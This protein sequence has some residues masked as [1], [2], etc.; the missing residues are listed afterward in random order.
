MIATQIAAGGERR[1][2]EHSERTG[3][4]QRG[5]VQQEAGG[6]GIFDDSVDVREPARTHAS[7]QEHAGRSLERAVPALTVDASWRST[8]AASKKP[9]AFTIWTP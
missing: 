1:H 9:V 5:D 8:A 4:D 7:V 6:D 2:Q 3:R